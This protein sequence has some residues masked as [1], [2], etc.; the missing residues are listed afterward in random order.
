MPAY[1]SNARLI[2]TPFHH[3]NTP[4]AYGCEPAGLLAQRQPEPFLSLASFQEVPGFIGRGSRISNLRPSGPKPDAL[5][6]CAMP[7]RTPG[8]DTRFGLVRQAS[9]SEH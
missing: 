8:F 3:A 5:P 7:R 1:A 4:A 9:F 6:D 2:S